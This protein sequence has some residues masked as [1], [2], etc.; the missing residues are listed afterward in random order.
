MPRRWLLM[1]LLFLLLPAGC[2]DTHTTPTS[3]AP[4][5]RVKLLSNVDQVLVTANQPPVVRA[6]SDAG[7]APHEFPRRP[8]GQ[9]RN[10]A[11][12]I[13]AH[14]RRSCPARVSL[15]SNPPAIRSLVNGSSYRGS[16]RLVPVGPGRFDVINDLD[17]DSYLKGVLAAEMPS[18]WQLEAFKAQ[19]ITARTYAL[20]HMKTD[21]ANRSYDVYSDTRSQMYTGVNAETDRTTQAVNETAGVVVAYG[22]PGDEHI[23]EAYFS[24]CCGGVS[25]SASDAFGGPNIEPLEAQNV[26]TLCNASPKFNWGPIIIP[27]SELTRRIKTWGATL[28]NPVK[29][30]AQLER[31]DIQF[32]NQYQRPI[33][34]L[35]TDT[36]GTNYSLTS[37]QTRNA[38]NADAGDGPKL[39]SSFCKPV[40]QPD[41]I[42]FV[43]GHGSGHGVGLCQW[44]TEARAEQGLTAEQIL[45]AAFPKAKLKRRIPVLW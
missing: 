38:C 17:L 23:F 21:G 44:C 9:S 10:R 45:T 32:V 15:S 29:N 26:G 12:W 40:T 34:F 25:Q 42:A 36:R 11:R 7:G 19:A 20:Y 27:K 13:L 18:R 43:E 16:Y 6:S 33:R 1:S 5:I 2:S 4:L 24:A 31:I 3:Q 35:I 28:D 37:E 39:F 30:M 41:S 22:P 14:R 8:T